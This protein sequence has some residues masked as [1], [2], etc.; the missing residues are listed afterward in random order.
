MQKFIDTAVDIFFRTRAI[1]GDMFGPYLPFLKFWAVVFSGVLMWGIIYTIVGSGYHLK[2]LDEFADLFLYNIVDVGKRRQLRAWRKI[3]K[4]A[5]SSDPLQW[6]QAI[7]L[8]DQLFDEILKMSG[9]RGATV[10]DRFQQ[11]PRTAISNYDQIQAAH[12]VR[13]R[14]RQE[15]DFS[16]T[17]DE[18]ITVLKAYEKAFKELGLI[19]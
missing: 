6:K 1:L 18:A 15:A 7:L 5:K 8:A 10:S 17:R 9:H 2:R 14:I 4:Q 11:L 13:D 3:V 19:S 12:R 16:L